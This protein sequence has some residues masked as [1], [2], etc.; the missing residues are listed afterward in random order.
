MPSGNSNFGGGGGAG[1]LVW[2]T[3]YNVPAGQYSI[4]VGDGGAKDN[5]SA[6]A[7]GNSGQDSTAFGLTA[8]GG[9]GGGSQGGTSS[10]GSGGS[11]IVVLR[12]PGPLGPSFTVAPGT[13]TKTTLPAPAGGCTVMSFT[14]TGT[15]T[16]S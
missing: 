16:I 4:V 6:G 1:G 10:G 14:V 2:V 13:N 7:R 8:K 11:G 3:G 5:S 15:L 9:G 12:A